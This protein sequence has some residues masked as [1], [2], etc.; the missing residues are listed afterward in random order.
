MKTYKITYKFT[1]TV[2]L[3]VLADSP[4][5]AHEE[6]MKEWPETDINFNHDFEVI[7]RELISIEDQNGNV[8]NFSNIE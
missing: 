5:T 1:G 8:T 2:T 3:P 4:E 6:A 7:D